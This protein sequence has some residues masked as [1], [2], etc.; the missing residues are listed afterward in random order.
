MSLLNRTPIR[1]LAA[2][3][4]ALAA[5][6]AH[7]SLT[8]STSISESVGSI[9]T[10]I[11]KSSESSSNTLTARGPY[12]VTD[13]AEVEGA[14]E[15]LRLALRAQQAGA[16]DLLLTLPRKA[17]AQ[18][19]ITV[20]TVIE[21]Q[22]RDYGVAFAVRDTYGQ[23]QPFFLVLEDAWHRELQSRPVAL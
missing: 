5:L 23:A 10:S 8:I 4:L 12:E 1:C 17:V 22:P 9:S 18:A 21:A 13:V 2:T 19:M 3:V 15:M 14:P 6:Q 20:G 7:A 11:Q 16:D